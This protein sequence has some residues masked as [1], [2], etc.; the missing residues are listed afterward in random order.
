MKTNTLILNAFFNLNRLATSTANI[1]S[2]SKGFR[3]TRFK[4]HFSNG[5]VP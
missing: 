3:I 2:K 5:C 4:E 1:M